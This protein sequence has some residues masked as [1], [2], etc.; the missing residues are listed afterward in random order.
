MR[1]DL[2]VRVDVEQ[3]AW[4]TAEDLSDSSR[5]L[6]NALVWHHLKMNFLGSL[7]IQEYY[8]GKVLP[9]L[10]D[11]GLQE[12]RLV[13]KLWKQVCDGLPVNLHLRRE[14]RLLQYSRQ[15]PNAKALSFYFSPNDVDFSPF[16]N[17]QSLNISHAGILYAGFLEKC[18][19]LKNL[20]RLK[21]DVEYCPLS[22]DA[23]NAAF[24]QLQRLVSLNFDVGGYGSNANEEHIPGF[25]WHLT[26]LTALTMLQPA[27]IDILCGAIPELEKIQELE[28]M[29]T[30][31]VTTKRELYFPSLTNLTKLTIREDQSRAYFSNQAVPI[32]FYSQVKIDH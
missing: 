26:N 4:S 2:E 15:F 22:A 7:L 29:M 14:N 28:V 25:V 6:T 23:L 17:L 19:V 27:Y 21:L 9:F 20:V 3:S 8:L 24:R 11:D 13:C 16:W 1:R 10:F 31:A 32:K 30:L 12:C 5:A 18:T